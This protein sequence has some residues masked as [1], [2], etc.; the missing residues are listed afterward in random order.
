M[1]NAYTDKEITNYFFDIHYSEFDNALEIFSRFFIDPLLSPEKINKE[2]NAVN[3][4]YE[5]NLI[6]DNR[7][8]SQIFSY[9]A[10]EDNPLHRF[11]TGNFFSLKNNSDTYHL[12]L[13]QEL[14]KLHNRYYTSDKMKLVIYSRDS[15]KDLEY[16]VWTKFKHVKKS[17]SSFLK[18]HTQRNIE[19]PFSDNIKVL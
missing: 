17:T 19:Q 6:S 16:I 3:S 11:S 13:E 10:K 18:N 15:I 7:K 4:E 8:K 9:L 5:K 12:N 2:I 1:F 14:K